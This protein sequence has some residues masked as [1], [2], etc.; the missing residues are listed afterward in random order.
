MAAGSFVPGG[1]RCAW[2]DAPIEVRFQVDGK[3]PLPPG[4]C[5]PTRD[6]GRWYE[7]P[8]GGPLGDW[9]TAPFDYAATAAG[10]AAPMPEECPA[11]PTRAPTHA[12]TPVV[13]ARLGGGGGTADGAPPGQCAPCAGERACAWCGAPGGAKPAVTCGEGT[14]AGPPR[15][16]S[17]GSAGAPLNATSAVECA[18]LRGTWTD[19]PCGPYLAGNSAL[20]RAPGACVAAD[21]TYMYTCA[22]GWRSNQSHSDG[23]RHDCGDGG[24]P[25]PTA[26]QVLPPT[27]SDE[28]LNRD[29]GWSPA[30][31]V[32]TVLGAI[33]MVVIAII[34]YKRPQDEDGDSDPDKGEGSESG[35]SGAN[36]SDYLA[37]VPGTP[38]GSGSAGLSLLALY[39]DKD[40]S[41][42]SDDGEEEKE[43]ERVKLLTGPARPTGTGAGVVTRLNPMVDL[44]TL[45]RY[46]DDPTANEGG[47]SET[48][49]PLSEA[50]GGSSEEIITDA[51]QAIVVRKDDNVEEKSETLRRL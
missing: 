1:L 43:G 13:C 36:G 30:V 31:I 47:S 26:E 15:L 25:A 34:V 50:V 4:R 44:N 8:G 40:E 19:L 35:S 48:S 10:R 51:A 38:G 37:I 27:P 42:S 7:C 24:T 28:E 14:C 5:V 9:K 29:K 21:S 41:S 49:S 17:A 22:T 23:D 6:A 20:S 3:P 18:R 32:V 12:P 2:C 46:D 33:I 16:G 11:G 39:D 45:A